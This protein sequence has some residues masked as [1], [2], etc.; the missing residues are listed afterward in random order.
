MRICQFSVRKIY[1]LNGKASIPSSAWPAALSSMKPPRSC[2]AQLSTAHGLAAR[3]EAAEALSSTNIFRLET[4]GVA[5]VCLV[6]MDASRPAH[7][8]YSVR[9][10]S[11]KLPKAIISWVAG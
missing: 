10:L 5:I 11:R 3:V 2:S 6:Y 4:T 1:R 7:M 8:R 9:R